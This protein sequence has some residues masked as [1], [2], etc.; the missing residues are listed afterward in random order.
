MEAQ[1]AEHT[2]QPQ[3][4]VLEPNIKQMAQVAGCK[5]LPCACNSLSILL[6]INACQVLPKGQVTKGRKPAATRCMEAQKTGAK[7]K[8][9]VKSSSKHK[10]QAQA[11][12]LTS[13][14][15]KNEVVWEP[16]R[17]KK[18]LI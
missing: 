3:Q 9:Q 13:A 18:E 10:Q 11:A 15:S 12:G 4:Q 6:K 16:Y 1:G 8:L 2:L 14:E 5:G 17:P 7:A